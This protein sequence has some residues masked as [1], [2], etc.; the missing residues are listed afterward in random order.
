MGSS[1]AMVRN[2]RKAGAQN[3]SVHTLH[4][5]LQPCW[6]FRI[7]GNAADER[8][9]PELDEGFARRDGS[10]SRHRPLTMNC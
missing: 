3:S 5:S 6:V 8:P 2:P 4:G 10:A 7:P 9:E 1:S